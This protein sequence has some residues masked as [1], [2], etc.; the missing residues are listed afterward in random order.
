MEKRVLLAVFLSFLV[1]FLYQ[2]LLPPPPPRAPEPVDRPAEQPEVVREPVDPAPP[3]RPAEPVPVEPAA[4]PLIHDVAAREI[5]L[6]TPHVRAVFSTRGAELRSWQLKHHLDDARRPLDLVPV[7]APEEMPRPFTLS[8]G[9]PAVDARLRQALYQ[10]NTD[11]LT[12]I[13]EPATLVFEYQEA[14]GLVVRKEFRFSPADHP[15]LVTFTASIDR[16]GETL[17]PTVHWG[18]AIG[19]VPRG[20]GSGFYYSQPSGG[21]YFRDGDVSRLSASKLTANPTHEGVF[22]FVGVDDHYFIS[23]ALPLPEPMRVEYRPVAAAVADAAPLV[24]YSARFASPPVELPFFFGPKDFDVLASVDRDLVRAIHFGFLSW[25]VVPLLRALKWIHGYVG[26]YGW[27]IIIL[28]VLINAAMFPLRHK[29]VVAMRKMQELQ[30]QVKAIQERYAKLKITDPERQKMNAEMMSLYREKG[31][32]PASGC[33]PMLLTMPV[34][35]AF[36]SLLSVAIEIRNAPFV[37][38]ITDLSV[39]DPW[40]VTPVLMGA[41]MFLQ[42]KMTPT[43]MD[44]M[45]QKIMLM[46]PVMFTFFFL[47][48]PSGLVLYWFT[49]NL[50]AIGQQYITNRIIGPPV[51]RPARPPAERRVKRSGGGKAGQA[52]RERA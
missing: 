8:V 16:G 42:Q 17:N 49:S 24:A 2:S 22:G 39:H 20:G 36:Y 44:P 34:L 26:N 19:G 21:I 46:M 18:P 15:Y 12:L 47:W 6:D 1:L 43:T 11:A 35:F 32:N 29:S 13:D 37:L 28:T 41:S 33:V 10:P 38:W 27:A 3:A 40:Y 4:E 50:W 31:V 51:V 7:E 52:A 25:L 14:G 48:A 45:Q 5:V 23:A 9:D 30:P